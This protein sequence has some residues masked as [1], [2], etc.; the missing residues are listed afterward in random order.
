MITA[1]QLK[2]ILPMVLV[3]LGIFI[4]WLIMAMR[5]QITKQVQKNEPPL[6]SVILVEPQ[7][8]R[9]SVHSQG[10]VTP[11]NEI[12]LI[13]EVFGKLIKL[14]PEFV[15]GGF[16]QQGD[17]LA[18]IDSRDYEAGIVLAQAQIAEAK[19]LMVME[20][21][22]AE[23]ADSEWQALGQGEPSELVMRVPQLAEARAKLK[24]AEANLL[25]AQIKR[26]R[27]ELR[28]PFTGRLQSK[29]VGLGQFIQAG[30]KLAR[31]YSTDVAEIRLPLT[32]S[33]LGY[34]NLQLGNSKGLAYTDEINP[35]VVLTAD[36]AG[37]MRT[38]QGRIVRTEGALDENTGVLYA[39]TEV[40]QPYQQASKSPP[41]LSNLFVKAEIE[42]KEVHGLFVLPQAAINALQ[43]ILIVD[44]G[45]KLHIRHVDVLRNEPDR[46]LVKSGLI[47]GD[48][49]IVSGV[50][51]PIEGMTVRVDKVLNLEAAKTVVR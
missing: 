22:Q 39:V 35:K 31:I 21:A 7:I 20:E 30:D 25:L 27:C 34:L 28:A 43:E 16:F 8:I 4:A 44:S 15:N 19:R 1:K 47:A 38:W 13:A 26:S 12:D 10:I 51:V 46:V 11:R 29:N 23:Q 18:S 6:V 32:N 33:Q 17:L 2:I 42:G 24:A 41:L 45:Q 14:H 36:I 5:P 9:L 49:V 48:R 3:V 37:V 40:L 50:D